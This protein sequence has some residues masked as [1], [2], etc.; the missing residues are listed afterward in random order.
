MY[1]NLN[2]YLAIP[3]YGGNV[4][5][6]TFQSVLAL[7]GWCYEKKINLKVQTLHNEA[8]ISRARNTLVAMMLDD[9]KFNA[10]HLLF[11]DSD[12][13][14]EIN[15]IERLFKI[16]K[17]IV[18]GCYA[19]KQIFWDKVIDTVNNNPEV[20]NNYQD[21]ISQSLNYN[22]NLD[23]EKIPNIVDG[24]TKVVDAATGM[25][26][27]KKEV[28]QIMKKKFPNKQYETKANIG[29]LKISS[30]NFYD[31]FSVGVYE[32][33]NKREY[34]SEDYYFSRLWQECG[35]EIWMDLESPLTHI[36]QMNFTGSAIKNFF[37]F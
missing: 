37:S 24:Y 23:A 36:G 21:L 34:L 33:N 29:G 8:L 25:M 20:K 4:T 1:Q 12:I 14:F 17:D 30:E 11:I 5:S 9:E 22:F 19:Q 3:C 15:N 28:F 18:C 2:L 26:L 10:S 31:F 7:V 13:K 32:K 6:G 16:N 27:I 35:G